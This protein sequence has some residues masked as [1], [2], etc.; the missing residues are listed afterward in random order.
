[1]LGRVCL[2]DKLV[3]ND[4]E[5]AFDALVRCARKIAKAAGCKR[6]QLYVPREMDARVVAERLDF[7]RCDRRDLT[8]RQRGKSGVW[9]TRSL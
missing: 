8:R 9:L 5:A 6:L 2:S 3:S 1:V 7:R 4:R